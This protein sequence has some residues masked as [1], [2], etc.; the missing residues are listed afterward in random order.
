MQLA[1]DCFKYAGCV[2][3]NE[4]EGSRPVGNHDLP[5]YDVQLP[6]ECLERDAR[7]GL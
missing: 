4:L 5:R 6:I 7:L 1:C 3:L 2:E